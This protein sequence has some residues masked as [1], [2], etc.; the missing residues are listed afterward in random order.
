MSVRKR[1][2]MTYEEKR[3]NLCKNCGERSSCKGICIDL[4]N[5]IVK[6]GKKD[7]RI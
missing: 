5:L 3:N 7:A 1:G 2:N 6:K 4:N